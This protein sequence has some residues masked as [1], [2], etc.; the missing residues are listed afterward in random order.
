MLEWEDVQSTYLRS[1]GIPSWE[2]DSDYPSFLGSDILK[3]GKE[4]RKSLLPNLKALS[5]SG[6]SFTSYTTEMYYALNV[7]K[8]R[9]LKLTNCESSL[10]LLEVAGRK[11]ELLRLKSFEFAM[12]IGW[13][14][15]MPEDI[16]GPMCLFLNSFTGLEDLSL[17]LRSEADWD[18]ICKAISTHISSLKRLVM[19]CRQDLGVRGSEDCHFTWVASLQSFLAG[20]HLDFVGS[21]GLEEIVGMSS[22]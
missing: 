18:L 12:D 17:M 3:L 4:H 13:N 1:L 22:A 16:T 5:L 20:S 9:S 19:N 8:L 14:E 15:E 2:I 6:I 21:S 11:G 10:E 7:A